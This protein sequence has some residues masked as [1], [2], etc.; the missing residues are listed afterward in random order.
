MKP[1]HVQQH[2]KISSVQ[3]TST[4]THLKPFYTALTIAYVKLHTT[5]K[6]LLPGIV[7]VLSD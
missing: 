4:T 6:L 5:T 7:F 3:A 1:T 2:K